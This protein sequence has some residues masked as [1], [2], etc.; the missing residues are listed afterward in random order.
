MAAPPAS[1]SN[2]A[3]RESA[4]R[5][6]MDEMESWRARAV[7]DT[8]APLAAEDLVRLLRDW[9]A[10]LG[11]DPAVAAGFTVNTVHYYR[12][13][14]VIDPPEGRTAAARYGLRHLWQIAGARLAGHLGLVTLAEARS[15][16][17]GAEPD[18]LVHFV[19]AR[20]TDA[21]AREM[22]RSTVAQSAALPPPP[23]ARA[24]PGRA[25]GPSAPASVAA[26]EPA[27]PPPVPAVVIPLPEGAWCVLPA[28]HA[29]RRSPDAA[30][31]LVRALA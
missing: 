27:D 2:G 29:A 3:T 10:A 31:E 16:M 14:D 28:A 25:T 12:R 8:A 24:L 13:R 5:Q 7:P 26:S 4:L 20:V 15:A 1:P 11:L 19:A 30:R 9:T 17:R 21:R 18:A 22:V 6:V 23:R